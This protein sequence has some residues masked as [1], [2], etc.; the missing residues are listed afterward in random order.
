MFISS[1]SR[2]GMATTT[3]AAPVARMSGSA[4]RGCHYRR[5]LSINGGAA[6]KGSRRAVLLRPRNHPLCHRSTEGQPDADV[7][8]EVD[9]TP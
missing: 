6:R 3:D 1:M 4:N 2:E 8:G 7:A 5:L 9:A